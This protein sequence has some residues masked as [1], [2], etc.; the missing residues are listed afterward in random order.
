MT[1]NDWKKIEADIWVPESMNDEISGRYLGVQH[2][3]GENQSELYS[4]EVSEGKILNFWG[5]KVLDGKMVGVQIGQQV[6]IV[7]LGKVKPEG[8]REY[9]DYD[10]FTK[11]ENTIEPPIE[12][13]KIDD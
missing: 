5:S 9:K 6:K 4:I 2:E 11:P 1:N 3:V 8:G 12:T 13:Q 10:V 7:F